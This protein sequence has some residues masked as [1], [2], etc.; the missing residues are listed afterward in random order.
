[1]S[2]PVWSD[3]MDSHARSGDR[4]RLYEWASL[5]GD[6]LPEEYAPSDED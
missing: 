6:K 2:Y 4:E 5:T 1:M 3:T